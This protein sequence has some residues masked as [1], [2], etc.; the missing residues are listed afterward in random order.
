MKK[1]LIL[2]FTLFSLFVLVGCQ[3]EPI[4]G[5]RGGGIRYVYKYNYEDYKELCDNSDGFYDEQGGRY[6]AIPDYQFEGVVKKVYE[7]ATIC[8][9]TD[10]ERPDDNISNCPNYRYNNVTI[11]CYT[12]EKNAFLLTYYDKMELNFWIYDDLYT[13]PIDALD[14]NVRYIAE[15]FGGDYKRSKYTFCSDQT[16]EEKLYKIGD[17]SFGTYTADYTEEE[18]KYWFDLTFNTMKEYHLAA[19]GKK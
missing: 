15:I 1:I 11:Y 5:E 6:E 18:I 9:C 2:V 4:P 13:Y 10:E 3:E 14:G 16:T 8:T 12:D 17:A 7:V 19:E